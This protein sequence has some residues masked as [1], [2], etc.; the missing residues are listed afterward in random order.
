MDPEHMAIECLGG[1]GGGG[2]CLTSRKSGSQG[3]SLDPQAENVE[4]AGLAA[5]QVFST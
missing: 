2:H 4:A 5:R 1:G 3:A